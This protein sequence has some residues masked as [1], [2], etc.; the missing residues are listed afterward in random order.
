M[1]VEIT[2]LH[3]LARTNGF[4]DRQCGSLG[5]GVDFRP[6]TLSGHDHDFLPPFTLA[7][8]TA[9][10]PN[11]CD[12]RVDCHAFFAER[13]KHLDHPRDPRGKPAKAAGQPW[14]DPRTKP[15]CSTMV[16]QLFSHAILAAGLG[17]LRLDRQSEASY[18][19]SA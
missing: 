10:K 6:T 12:A 3:V 2:K 1:Y 7:S 11:V 5:N 9:N 14:S 19:L 18:W 4:G 15:R 13:G 8:T 17:I 16:R